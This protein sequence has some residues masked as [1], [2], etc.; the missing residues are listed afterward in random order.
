MSH[1]ALMAEL[2]RWAREDAHIDPKKTFRCRF[3]KECNASVA[4]NL[5]E[6][7]YCSMS[8]VGRHFGADGA[9]RLAVVGMDHGEEFAADFED[10][11][12][13]IE[14][15]YQKEGGDFNSHYEGVVRTAAA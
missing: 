4:N 7:K 15:T 5:C 1:D 13:G 2:N 14:K 3:Y 8:Y 11:R 12:S 6:G 10:R 9:F